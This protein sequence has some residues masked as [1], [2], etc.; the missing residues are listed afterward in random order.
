MLLKTIK[1]ISLSLLFSTPLLAIEAPALNS[2]AEVD[3]FELFTFFVDHQ[4]KQ[5]ER[6]AG[7]CLNH[8][9][10]KAHKACE[11]ANITDEQK[12]TIKQMF[13]EFKS[14]IMPLARAARAAHKKFHMTVMN[15]DS[16]ADDITTAASNMG[17]KTGIVI[18]TVKGFLANTSKT[19]FTTDQ[20]KKGLK[21]L[22]L[23][24]RAH[25]MK[26]RKGSHPKKRR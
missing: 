19:V 17:K 16:S 14:E 18:G 21:C 11:A 20:F 13:G 1:A 22:N 26:H 5:S 25:A 2:I 24:T 10:E 3:D 8:L 12:A 9:M 6:E 23:T 4:G 15:A 7:P